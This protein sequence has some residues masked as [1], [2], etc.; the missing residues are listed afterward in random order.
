MIEA[1]LLKTM[2]D[3]QEVIN[4][5]A[6]KNRK[7]YDSKYKGNLAKKSSLTHE[8]W[9]AEYA[10]ISHPIAFLRG[11]TTLEG[12][13]SLNDIN[14]LSDE[15]RGRIK[16]YN[17]YHPTDTISIAVVN[18]TR[19]I[20]KNLFEYLPDILSNEPIIYVF[21]GRYIKPCNRYNPFIDPI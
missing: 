19:H 12:E 18:D 6:T 4:T 7:L 15:L 20:L 2:E 13:E 11:I 1:A 21:Q 10:A 9:E 5:I 3:P 14:M 16:K 17:F 8:Q